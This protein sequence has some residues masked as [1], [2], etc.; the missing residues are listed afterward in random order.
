[1]RVLELPLPGPLLLEPSIRADSRGWVAETLRRDVFINFGVDFEVIQ[2]TISLTKRNVIRGLYYQT[3]GP[4]ARLIRVVRGAVFDVL[5]DVRAG[6]PSHGKWCGIELSDSN[7]RQI[8]APSGF[9]HGYLTLTDE[10]LTVI[11]YDRPFSAR[12]QVGIRWDDPD[13]AI[14]WPIDD[15]IVD[16]P[17]RLSYL[18]DAALPLPPSRPS[19][20]TYVRPL[21]CFLSHATSDIAFVQQLYDD[22]TRSGFNCWFAPESMEIGS[23]IR[24]SLENAVKQSDR[25]V[26]VLSPAAIAS[27]W[28]ESEVEATLER[29]RKE[30]IHIIYPVTLGNDTFASECPWLVHLRRTRHIGDFSQWQTRAD[31]SKALTK[32]TRAL[33]AGA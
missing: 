15:P 3:D 24:E 28:V 32:L 7:F 8:Y 30:H 17:E 11:E 10:S 29:E 2:Q 20:A 9:A 21:S 27:Q 14:P 4:Q 26:L 22:L 5:V 16:A 33:L 19:A 31:Y 12:T 25:V 23:P 6:S 18:R 13:L 1:M